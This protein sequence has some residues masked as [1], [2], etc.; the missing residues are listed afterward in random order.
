[1]SQLAALDLF[2]LLERTFRRRSRN[3]RGCGFSLPFRLDDA[4]SSNW[5]V[6]PDSQ[7]CSPKCEAILEDVVA[8]FQEA[9][10]LAD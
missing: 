2:V 4:P 5:S 8:E 1:M 9:Y 6:I 3:C 10:R 7:T